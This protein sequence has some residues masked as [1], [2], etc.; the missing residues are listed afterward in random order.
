MKILVKRLEKD[1]MTES[2]SSMMNLKEPYKRAPFLRFHKN[3]LFAGYSFEASKDVCHK[4]KT[5][6]ADPVR[7]GTE[8]CNCEP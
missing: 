8:V 5:P 6:P 1:W 2:E 7:L 4:D 3:I